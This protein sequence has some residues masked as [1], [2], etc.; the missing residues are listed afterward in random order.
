MQGGHQTTLKTSNNIMHVSVLIIYNLTSVCIF[1][2]LFLYTKVLTG[3]IC[4]TVEDFFMVVISFILMTLMYDFVGGG[5]GG[6]V[7]RN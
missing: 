5:G 2:K 1:Y 4:L 6:I 3:R 7:R